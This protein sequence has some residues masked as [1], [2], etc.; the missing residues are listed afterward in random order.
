MSDRTELRG[1]TALVTGASS[2]IGEAVARQM[3]EQGVRV[4]LV[5]RRADRLEA[6]QQA[7]AKGG[8]EVLAITGD[9]ADPSQIGQIADA[10]HKALGRIDILV[11]NA[12][13]MPL[14]TVENTDPAVT[15][16]VFDTNVLGLAAMTHAV[17]PGMLARGQGDIVNLASV[18]ARVARPGGAAYSASKFAVAGYSEA[19]RQEVCGR[20][21]RVMVIEPGI[22]ETELADK[23]GDDKSRQAIKERIATMRPLQAQDVAR[24]I[25]FALAQPRHVTLGEILIRSTDQAFP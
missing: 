24:L 3:A 12:G 14:G 23:V 8:G 15:R 7:I 22:V 2:G 4:A 17:L 19:L 20:G 1:A 9:I 6:L 5:G 10:A 25:V 16:A 13:I 21:I 11:N 18:V